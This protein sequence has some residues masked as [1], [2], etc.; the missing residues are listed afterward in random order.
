MS[1]KRG[2]EESE[3]QGNAWAFAS[4]SDARA[5]YRSALAKPGFISD[6]HDSSLDTG[7]FGE[8]SVLVFLWGPRMDR[9]LVAS[10]ERLVVLRGGN[11]MEEN[12]KQALLYQAQLRQARLRRRAAKQAAVRRDDDEAP[13]AGENPH[14]RAGLIRGVTYRSSH[15]A[16]A[17]L[18]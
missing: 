16:A 17:R 3:L 1:K 9:E 18:P 14:E 6:Q 7:F 8:R 15:R 4:S 13:S 12:L 5:A 2:S 10:V 11:E